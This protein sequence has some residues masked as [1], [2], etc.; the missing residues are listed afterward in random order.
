MR[1][2]QAFMR[3]LGRHIGPDT[4]IPAGDIGVGAREL[5]FLFGQYRRQRGDFH[6]GVLTGKGIGWGGSHLRPEATGYGLVYF[7]QLMLE[8]AASARADTPSLEHGQQSR[9][10]GKA[11]LISGSGNV[12]LFAAEKVIELGGSVLTLSDSGGTL[13]VP[14]GLSAAMLNEL[15]TFKLVDRGRLADFET[16]STLKGAATFLPGVKPW[17][18]KAD[19]ALPCAT[20]NELDEDDAKQLVANG[21]LAVAEGANMPTTREAVHVRHRRRHWRSQLRGRSQPRRL[22]QGGQRHAGK[23]PLNVL[24]GAHQTFLSRSSASTSARTCTHRALLSLRPWLLNSLRAG[25][26]GA[27]LHG[28]LRRP[29]SLTCCGRTR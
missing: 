8:H 14:G 15:C 16:L 27:K 26:P 1:F 2:C 5:G 24:E 13:Y 29:S 10:E 4:D 17:G 11:V 20:Q 19:V 22:H 21:V 28:A 3:E 7:T 23:R 9:L 25:S 6:A 12:A 18:I